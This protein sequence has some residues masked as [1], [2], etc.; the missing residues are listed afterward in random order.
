MSQ[1][2]Q[3]EIYTDGGC[4]P[5]PGKGAWA[6]VIIE[7]NKI[8]K[9]MWGTDE[10]TTNNRMEYS[11]LINALKHIDENQQVKAF[12][13]SKLLVMTFNEWM[14]KWEQKSWKKKEPIKNLDLV[15]QLF[16]LKQQKPLVK[17][18]WVKAH[19]GNKWNE[20]VDQLCSE[21]IQTI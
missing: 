10:E 21:A 9:E 11:A 5:N 17:L 12:S 13:D 6:F 14:M 19:N 1:T 3:I 20:Y 7:N 18:S 8:K 4:D 15:K 16:E 2:T